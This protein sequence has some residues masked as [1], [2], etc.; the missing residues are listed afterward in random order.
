MEVGA[1]NPRNVIEARDVHHRNAPIPIDVTLPGIITEVSGH[2]K[3]PL[4]ELGHLENAKS[5]MAATPLP[6]V[7]E[8]RLPH[9]A[10]TKDPMDVTLLGITTEVS[11]HPM[12]TGKPSYPPS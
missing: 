12:V 10:N 4:R 5:P 1:T 9:E 11:G 7:T 2:P 6:M 8:V 3:W